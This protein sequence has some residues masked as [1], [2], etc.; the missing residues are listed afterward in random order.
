MS[1]LRIAGEPLLGSQRAPPA[2]RFAAHLT[3]HMNVNHPKIIMAKQHYVR[4]KT[5]HLLRTIRWCLAVCGMQ[6]AG[7]RLGHDVQC[8]DIR[9]NKRL[10]VLIGV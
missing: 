5:G 8:H 4:A 7:Q 1:R 10:V 2:S 9:V 6:S 3:T